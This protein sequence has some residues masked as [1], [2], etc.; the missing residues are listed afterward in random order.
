MESYKKYEIR[1]RLTFPNLHLP[2]TL[3]V[4]ELI[5]Q[6]QKNFPKIRKKPSHTADKLSNN[7]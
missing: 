4:F 7:K 6:K 3:P 2:P 1:V 5:P